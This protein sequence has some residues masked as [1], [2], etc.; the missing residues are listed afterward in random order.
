MLENI[1]H[2]NI[3]SPDVVLFFMS[4]VLIALV[5]WVKHGFLR[6]WRLARWVI[7]DVQRI[8]QRRADEVPQTEGIIISHVIGGLGVFGIT[9]RVLEIKLAI[10]VV[11]ALFMI[12]QLSGFILSWIPR[13][14]QLSREH[15]AMDRHMK[16]WFGLS[17]ALY[18]LVVSL[19]PENSPLQHIGIFIALWLF[20][21]FFR[22]VRVLQTSRKRLNSF[23]YGF[24]YL[25][26]LEILPTIV[27]AQLAS[28]SL[29][30]D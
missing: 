18:T 15:L 25:C 30:G 11:I 24:L 6:E 3:D 29:A 28:T 10:V 21:V 16:M 4:L 12:R 19:Q 2:E 20:W 14:A 27:L 13:Y 26:A 17:V 22:I 1:P 9:S 7:K 23:L 8:W 5:V